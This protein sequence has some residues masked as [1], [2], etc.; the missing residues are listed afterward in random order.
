MPFINR[1]T[2]PAVWAVALREP[3]VRMER[4]RVWDGVGLGLQLRKRRTE[5][6][7]EIVL[8]LPIDCK[9]ELQGLE[10]SQLS[11]KTFLIKK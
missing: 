8:S 6:Y 7:R 11:I 9:D 3:L 2:G 5:R 10:C 1:Q 4:E